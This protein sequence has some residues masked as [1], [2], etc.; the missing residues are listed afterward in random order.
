VK[1]GEIKIN[2]AKM[3]S[4]VSFGLTENVNEIFLLGPPLA[5]GKVFLG[6]MLPYQASDDGIIS[7]FIGVS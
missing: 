7:T 6:P 3:E 5:G 1:E 2:Q 4:V